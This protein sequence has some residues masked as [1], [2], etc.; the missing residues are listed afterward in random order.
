[1]PQS[2]L[3]CELEGVLVAYC[4]HREESQMGTKIFGVLRA[5]TMDTAVL[6]SVTP[7]RLPYRRSKYVL[8][9]GRYVSI[10]TRRHIPRFCNCRLGATAVRWRRLA[11]STGYV[12]LVWSDL[13]T[14]RGIDT[15]P[16][17]ETFCAVT[18]A[19]KPHTAGLVDLRTPKLHDHNINPLTS[20]GY[21]MY[22]Q[23]FYVLPTQCICVFCMDL[24]TNSDY[25]P[26][27]Y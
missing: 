4:V 8:P 19:S 21:Y 12:T 13:G 20:S 25:F 27:Q 14:R 3:T 24:R 26:I 5:V 22:I 15:L 10:T 2:P 16:I 18:A 1:M 7:C 11:V 17:L 6:R 23:Q 9:K